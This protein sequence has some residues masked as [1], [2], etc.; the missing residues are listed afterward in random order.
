M[1]VTQHL[2]HFV[3]NFMYDSYWKLKVVCNV[4]DWRIEGLYQSIQE[5]FVLFSYD[6]FDD[7]NYIFV[8]I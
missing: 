6:F 1:F 8:I 4:T 2:W 3:K 5:Q 7:F